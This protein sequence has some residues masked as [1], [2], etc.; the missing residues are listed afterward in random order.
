MCGLGWDHGVV[1]H[2][3]ELR[4]DYPA[5]VI[6][7]LALFDPQPEGEPWRVSYWLDYARDILRESLRSEDPE[8]S[9]KAKEI[10]NRWVARGHLSLIELLERSPELP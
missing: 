10:I 7:T 8:V 2:L 9:S 4:G 6:D 3:A 1:E 5:E